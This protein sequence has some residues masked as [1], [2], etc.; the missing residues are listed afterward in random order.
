MTDGTACTYAA[1]ILNDAGLPTTAENL[2]KLIEAAGVEVRATV[3]IIYSRF[4]EKKSV[5]SL[6]AQASAAPVAAAAPA[7][8]GAPAAG[9]KEEKKAVVEEEDDDF[10]MGGLF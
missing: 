10:G 8:A 6:V 3:P 7:A 9:K 4:L 5:D 2:S 1:L